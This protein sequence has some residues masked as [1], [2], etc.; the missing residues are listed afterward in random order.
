M[1]GG[2]GGGSGGGSGGAGDAARPPRHSSPTA[3]GEPPVIHQH[4]HPRTPPRT[5]PRP[6]CAT[7]SNPPGPARK[8]P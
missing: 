4:L 8:K 5:T 6:P 2:E 7:T 1:A 3:K